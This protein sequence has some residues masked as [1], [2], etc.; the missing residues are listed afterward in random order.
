MSA[1]LTNNQIAQTF[2]LIEEIT[3]KSLKQGVYEIIKEIAQEMKWDF[4]MIFQK[5]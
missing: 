5:I 2:P 4:F 1:T 3:D